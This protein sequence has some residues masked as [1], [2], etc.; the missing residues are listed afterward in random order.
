MDHISQQCQNCGGIDLCDLQGKYVEK[1][2]CRQLNTN[3][4]LERIALA[5]ERM[6]ELD[7]RR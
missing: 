4:L 7:G 3:L 5:L 6:V 2:K 1:H